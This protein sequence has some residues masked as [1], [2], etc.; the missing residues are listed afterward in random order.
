MGDR[1][2]VLKWRKTIYYIEYSGTRNIFKPK[3][4]DKIS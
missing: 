3:I 4:Y 2:I 1:K